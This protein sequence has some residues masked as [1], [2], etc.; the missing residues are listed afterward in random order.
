MLSPLSMEVNILEP[1]TENQMGSRTDEPSAV[2]KLITRILSNSAFTDIT[3]V[4]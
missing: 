3:L 4:A 1:L 2:Q